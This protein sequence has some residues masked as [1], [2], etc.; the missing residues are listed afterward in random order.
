MSG[1][2]LQDLS[3][4]QHES[5][6]LNICSTSYA[7]SEGLNQAQK[8]RARSREQEEAVRTVKDDPQF[9]QQRMNHVLNVSTE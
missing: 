3:T 2:G 7:Y 6:C 8:S 5:S 4:I 9:M 1:T